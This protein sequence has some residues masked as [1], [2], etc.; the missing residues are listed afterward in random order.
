MGPR[1]DAEL[2]VSALRQAVKRRR[3]DKGLV[4]QSDRGVQYASGL[5]R[6][7]LERGGFIQSMSRK[8]TAGTMP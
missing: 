4:F 2:I 5:F 3:P 6:A 1:I 8:G 7:E